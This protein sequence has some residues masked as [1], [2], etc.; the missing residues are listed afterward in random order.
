LFL[1]LP[2]KRLSGIDLLFLF[3]RLSLLV[4]D[5]AEK[6]HDL[7]KL[8]LIPI[9]SAETVKSVV[10][11]LELPEWLAVSRERSEPLPVL[12]PRSHLGDGAEG[13]VEP[14]AHLPLEL[15]EEL[16]RW[17]TAVG[18]PV[19][20]HAT[21]FPASQLFKCQWT[22]PPYRR[23]GSGDTSPHWACY[24][25]GERGGC[26]EDGPHPRQLYVDLLARAMYPRD[27]AK[28]EPS[29]ETIREV[30]RYLSSRGAS[31]GGKARKAKL[32]PERRRE[33]ARK[34]AQA[35]WAHKRDE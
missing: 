32:S 26:Q 22:N 17:A 27:M 6:K 34:A 23:R 21:Q 19:V 12:V 5:P 28:T 4:L 7:Y 35:R 20:R 30:M 13:T 24:H 10:M 18:A 15:L 31:K 1:I 8:S 33:I 2:Q 14:L 3:S 16:L 11:F 9:L 25:I 29:A